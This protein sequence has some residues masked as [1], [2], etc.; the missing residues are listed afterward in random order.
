V[1]HEVLDVLEFAAAQYP[2]GTDCEP[3]PKVEE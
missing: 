1:I 2:V 3:E